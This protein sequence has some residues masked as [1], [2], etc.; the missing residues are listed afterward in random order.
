MPIANAS[1]LD[2]ATAAAEAMFMFHNNRSKNKLN[3]AKSFLY[4]THVFL[5]R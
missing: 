3:A 5:K 4:Q 1:L 2:E